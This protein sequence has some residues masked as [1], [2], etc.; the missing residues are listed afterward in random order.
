[1]RLVAPK[2]VTYSRALDG[3]WARLNRRRARQT[4]RSGRGRWAGAPADPGRPP[5][6]ALE[7]ASLPAGRSAPAAHLT[8]GYTHLHLPAQ[9]FPAG[10]GSP[11]VAAGR[12]GGRHPAGI[13]GVR[14]GQSSHGRSGYRRAGSPAG[15]ASAAS[16]GSRQSSPGWPVP[17]PSGL[18]RRSARSRSGRHGGPRPPRPADGSLVILVTLSRTYRSQPSSGPTRSRRP[19]RSTPATASYRVPSLHLTTPLRRTPVRLPPPAHRHTG[20]QTRT[21]PNSR[22]TQPIGSTGTRTR[23]FGFPRHPP[24]RGNHF[25]L[26]VTISRSST[27]RQTFAAALPGRGTRHLAPVHQRV[28]SL[29]IEAVAYTKCH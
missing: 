19:Y 14:L 11:T 18:T 28:L 29:V 20:R 1:M 2:A 9:P 12:G 24:G 17:T 25:S 27:A 10:G 4:R 6:L 13:P 15:V 3:G 7:Q 5:I 8:G 22:S 23:A 16:A 26:F 21:G